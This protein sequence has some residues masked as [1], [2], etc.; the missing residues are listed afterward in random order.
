MEFHVAPRSA[1]YELP[2]FVPAGER[3]TIFRWRFPS[4]IGKSLKRKEIAAIVTES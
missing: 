1:G 2:A 3:P 4:E